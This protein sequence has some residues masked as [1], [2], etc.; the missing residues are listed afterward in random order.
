[1]GQM[2]SGHTRNGLPYNR[3]GRGHDDIVVFQG[4]LFENKPLSGLSAWYFHRIYG[5]LAHEHNVWIVN[6]RPDLPKDCSLK[7]MSDEYATMIRE[8]FEG[9]VDVVGVSTGGLIA[10]HFATDHHDLTR[11]LVI[12]S[13]AHC[14]SD[15]AKAF[16]VRLGDLVRAHRWRAA[17]A[18]TLAFMYSR[19]GTAGNVARLTARLVAPLGGTLFGK[20][21]D[22]SDLL[23]TQA[24]AEKHNFKARLA[25]INVP[26]LVVGGDRDPFYT[27]TLFRETAEGIPNARLIVYK[28]VG[29]P[30]AGRGFAEDVLYFLTAKDRAL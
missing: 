10:Q 25:E 26:T 18:E 2:I 4:L 3:F 28:G 1:M 7:D 20:P 29:H 12:Q 15:E 13:S 23:V 27:H 9:P 16:Q 24:A 6:R 21:T 19:Y 22:P 5:R 11:R 30:A 8:E 17:Y 14:L